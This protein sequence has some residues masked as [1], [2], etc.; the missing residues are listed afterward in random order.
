MIVYQREVTYTDM[1][2]GIRLDV[3]LALL[4]TLEITTK[5]QSATCNGC[6]HIFGRRIRLQRSKSHNTNQRLSHNPFE[7]QQSDNLATKCPPPVPILPDDVCTV[8]PC[9][10]DSEC[11]L[12]GQKCCYNGCLNSCVHVVR[13]PPLIDWLTRSDKNAT[14]DSVG[15]LE[16]L[17]EGNLEFDIIPGEM[18]VESHHGGITGEMCSTTHDDDDYPMECP[19]GYECHVENSGNLALGIPNRGRCIAINE[20]APEDI[21][22]IGDDYPYY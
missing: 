19:H 5:G 8:D 12:P 9:Q 11:S 16:D 13:P 7:N 14:R 22:I 10:S 20:N 21:S 3:I 4:L 6:L 18:L 17:Y 15:N 2:V 1:D